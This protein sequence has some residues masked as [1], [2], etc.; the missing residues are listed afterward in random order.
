MISIFLGKFKYKSTVTPLGALLTS[1]I[2]KKI[3]IFAFSLHVKKVHEEQLPI[4]KILNKNYS[5]QDFYGKLYLLLM[6]V[7]PVEITNTDLNL[8]L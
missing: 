3:S 4:R 1:L 6:N 5:Y 8:C 2:N 7:T